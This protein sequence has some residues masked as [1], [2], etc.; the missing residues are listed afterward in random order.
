MFYFGLAKVRRYFIFHSVF[1]KGINRENL[2]EYPKSLSYL[3][4]ALSLMPKSVKTYKAIARVNRKNKTFLNAIDLVRFPTNDELYAVRA[5]LQRKIKQ[6]DEALGSY[7]LAIK[8]NGRNTDYYVLRAEL[9]YLMQ[10]IQGAINDYT[11]A[12]DIDKSNSMLY[13][14]RAFLNFERKNYQSAIDDYKKAL[15][16]KPNKAHL[17]FMLGS[18]ERLANLSDYNDNFEKAKKL[19]LA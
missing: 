8:Y 2:G 4:L 6:Y 5:D 18:T 12:I 3:F 10:D 13:E 7:N 14:Q 15:E 16:L 1:N 19:G 11:G 17:Y 9:K